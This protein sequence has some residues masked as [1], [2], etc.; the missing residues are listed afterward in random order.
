[1]ISDEPDEDADALDDDAAIEAFLGDAPAKPDGTP[2][3][4][5]LKDWP[6]RSAQDLGLSVDADTLAWFQA[7]YADWRR[8]IRAV[9]RSWMIDNTA[10]SNGSKLAP[11]GDE[12]TVTANSTSV[13]AAGS[14]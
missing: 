8:Q 7:T 3:P 5:E 11:A 4:T 14:M 13:G 2:A 12:A 10:E 6:P 9:L 1:M